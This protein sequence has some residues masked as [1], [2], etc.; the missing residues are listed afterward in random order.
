[1]KN[2][3]KWHTVQFNNSKYGC[4]KF[5][6]KGWLYLMNK[7]YTGFSILTPWTQQGLMFNTKEEIQDRLKKVQKYIA[8]VV[9]VIK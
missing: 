1:M 8:T 7:D 5:T 6:V 9:K 3:F 2:I 4:R